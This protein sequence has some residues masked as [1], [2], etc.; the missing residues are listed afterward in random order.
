MEYIHTFFKPEVEG[1]GMQLFLKNTLSQDKSIINTDKEKVYAILTNL[2]KNA[3]KFTHKGSIEFGYWKKGGFLEFYVKDTGSGISPE[4]I[5]LI[6]ERFRQGSE[7]ITRNFEGAGLGLSISKAYVEM[8]GGKIWADSELEKGSTF[9][10][11][12]PYDVPSDSG[13]VN[14]GA[15]LNLPEI[16]I[17]ENLKILI[18]EDDKISEQ[19]ITKI[20]KQ[21]GCEVLIARN[22][23]E[24]VEICRKNS[25]I[26]LVL[27]DIKMPQMDGHEAT[28]QIRLFNQKVVIIAQTAYGL[29]SDREKAIK[30]GCNDYISKPISKSA[31]YMVLQNHFGRNGG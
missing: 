31:L 5:E 8:L 26:D 21:I 2:V 4:K 14:T 30:A 25:D 22:G 16:D 12:I 11:T 1:K 24:A 9:Y 27:M 18:A 10:F 13:T 19:L 3:I 15:L 6:F 29:H 17:P 7:A 23:I 20:A 28:R